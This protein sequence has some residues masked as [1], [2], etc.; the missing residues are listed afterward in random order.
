ME[1]Q[2]TGGQADVTATNQKSTRGAR[3]ERV[4]TSVC[5]DVCPLMALLLVLHLQSLL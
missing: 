4:L 1:P 2:R 3:M 5:A